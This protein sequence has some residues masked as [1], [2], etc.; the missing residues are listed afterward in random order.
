MEV[1]QVR[2][3]QR[4]R[5]HEHGLGDHGQVG[6]IRKVRGS[7]CYVHLDWDERPQHIVWFYATDLEQVPDEPIPSRQTG[8]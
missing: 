1:E 8:W 5:V 7:R 6:T 3:G 4:I 2:V